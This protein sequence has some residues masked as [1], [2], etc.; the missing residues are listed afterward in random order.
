MSLRELLLILR[1][2]GAGVWLGANVM[3]AVVPRM[4]AN[5]GTQALAGLYRVAS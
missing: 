5:Q 4:V 1:F 2:A 3:Q